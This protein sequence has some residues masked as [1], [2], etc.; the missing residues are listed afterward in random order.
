[1]QRIVTA[2]FDQGM[3]QHGEVGERVNASRRG[4]PFIQVKGRPQLYDVWQNEHAGS[5]AIFD[6]VTRVSR[7]P[8]HWSEYNVRT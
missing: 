6:P 2:A 5:P 1:M 4:A 3:F 7:P 8:V